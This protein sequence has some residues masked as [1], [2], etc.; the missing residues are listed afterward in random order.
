MF[1]SKEL[2]EK[3]QAFIDVGIQ[4]MEDRSKNDDE[5]AKDEFKCWERKDV[6]DVANNVSECQSMISKMKSSKDRYGDEVEPADPVVLKALEE[7]YERLKGKFVRF[8]ATK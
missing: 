8:A 3:L 2:D 6:V 4:Q 7:Y 5:V 1:M